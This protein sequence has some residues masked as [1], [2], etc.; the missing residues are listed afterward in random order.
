[1]FRVSSA[2][3]PTSIPLSSSLSGF[4]LALPRYNNTH[5][6]QHPTFPYTT[7]PTSFDDD[8]D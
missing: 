8:Y 4:G 5:G 3:L 1:M 7:S 6:H 2:P